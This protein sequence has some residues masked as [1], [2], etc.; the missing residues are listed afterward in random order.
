MDCAVLFADVAGST[1]LYEMLGDE[2]AFAL[3]EGCLTLMSGCTA[4]AQGRVVKTIGDA[5]MSVFPSADAAA[6][7]AVEMQ[8]RVEAHGLAQGVHLGLRIGFHFGPVV[9]HDT[10]VFGDTVNLASR[11]C[12]LASRGQIVTDRDTAQ[13]LGERFLGDLRTLYAI[14]VKGKQDE[15]DLIELGWQASGDEKT[16]I[17]AARPAGGA[18]K[19]LLELSLDSQQLV[20]GPDRRKVTM[21]RDLEADF[22]I[23][24]RSASRAHAMIERRREHFVLADHSA[25][26]C[27]VTFEGRPEMRVHH[28]EL[29]LVGHGWI[30]FGQPSAEAAQVA[31]FRCV[32]SAGGGV[33]Q[34]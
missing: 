26:G 14:P 23:R 9:A 21:G 7:A 32:E 29:T 11:L 16:I 5:V 20:M 31:E 10:D 13:T 17:V 2:R 33:A 22:V 30:A 3:V 27:F 19:A 18:A 6:A 28:E 25:N 34:C 8:S 24:G 15:V 1:A 4:Q 12:D